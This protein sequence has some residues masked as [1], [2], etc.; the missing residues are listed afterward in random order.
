MTFGF[1]IYAEAPTSNAGVVTFGY[2]WGVLTLYSGLLHQQIRTLTLNSSM[3]TVRRMRISA[4]S[5]STCRDPIRSSR[6][7]TGFTG[8]VV[9]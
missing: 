3:S 6:N 8:M 4:A 5:P 2:K 1:G 7:S 9:A